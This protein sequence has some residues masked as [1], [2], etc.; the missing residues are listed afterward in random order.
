MVSLS[1]NER[2][3][4]QDSAK[5]NNTKGIL[6]L[7]NK[8]LKF[9][10]M[11]RGIIFNGNYTSLDLPLERISALSF[12]GTGPFKKL[13]INLIREN[14]PFGVLR[15]EFNING[16]EKWITEIEVTKRTKKESIFTIQKEIKEIT[17]EIVK[18]R[19]TYCGMLVEQHLSRC[20]NCNALQ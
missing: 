6:Y 18:I 12:V 20:P 5:Y 3:L 13:V 4:F 19:C 1:L 11:Q 17:K 8:K 7:T 15:H 2:V 9:E 14:P 16:P 10:Y